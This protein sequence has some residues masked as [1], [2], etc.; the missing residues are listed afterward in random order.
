M[1][2]FDCGMGYCSLKWLYL[3]AGTFHVIRANVDYQFLPRRQT[4]QNARKEKIAGCEEGTFAMK[5]KIVPYNKNRQSRKQFLEYIKQ[6]FTRKF[7]VKRNGKDT[8]EK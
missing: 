8:I 6:F 2:V 5:W 3:I 7:A 4:Q 1:S